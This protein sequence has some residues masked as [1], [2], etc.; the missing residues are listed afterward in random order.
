MENPP[1]SQGAKHLLSDDSNEKS[2]KKRVPPF[3][4]II[5]NSR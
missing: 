1:P 4:P 3:F 5:P 2:A